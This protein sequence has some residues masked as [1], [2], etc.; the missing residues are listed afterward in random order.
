MAA[1]IKSRVK[2]GKKALADFFS[3]EA[4]SQYLI[5]GPKRGVL[6]GRGWE[7]AYS[8]SYIFDDIHNNVPNFTI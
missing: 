5:S 2:E 6:M 1:S 7:G 4:C 8:K 3:L